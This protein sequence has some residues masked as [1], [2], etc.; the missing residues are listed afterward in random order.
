MHRSALALLA[1]SPLAGCIAIAG[2]SD[3]NVDPC[4]EN[5]CADGASPDVSPGNDAPNVPDSSSGNVDAS[6]DTAADVVN[7]SPPPSPG[8]STVALAGTGVAVG[9]TIVAT[10]TAKDDTG[11][12]VTRVGSNVVFTTSGGTSVVSIGAVTDLGDGHYRA[13]FTGVTEGTPIQVSATID[14]APLKTP[15]ASLRVVNRVAT[16]LVVELDA[17]NADNA[18]NRGGKGCPAAG[19]TTWTDLGASHFAGTLTGFAGTCAAGSGWAGAGTPG[20]PGRLVFDG[21]DDAV[22]FG[23]VASV[24]KYTL[25]V[26]TRKTGAGTE[27]NSGS[28]GIA[29][30]FPIVAKGT[31]EAEM[32]A[33]DINYYLGITTANVIGFDYELTG[34]SANTPILGATTLVDNQWI[35]MGATLDSPTT[36]SVWLDGVAD[37][38][39]APPGA[40][41]S[42]TSSRFVVGGSN[43]SN[44]VALG[45]FKGEVAVVL[46][47]DRALSADEIK[48]NCHSYSSRFGTTS[49]AP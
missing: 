45:R 39:V 10:L 19:L 9:R 34:T 35:M 8:L 24:A 6:A 28:G 26:W 16:G 42:A 3:F 48:Q 33:I 7:D 38:T 5:G 25:L 47:Y 30:A 13:T 21:V 2:V 1:L 49:C 46:L 4:L 41:A 18:G 17:E 23:A 22:D 29:A 14:G 20:D 31:A 36:R 11:N 37:A 27:G 43:R 44:G 15:K 12:P 40:P 32:A